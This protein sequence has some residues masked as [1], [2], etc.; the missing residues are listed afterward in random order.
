M[1]S[2]N[3]L[4]VT[5]NQ[6]CL[7]RFGQAAKKTGSAFGTT[8]SRYAAYQCTQYFGN[9]YAD[10]YLPSK[11][12][13]NL[14]YQNLKMKEIGGFSSNYYWSSS[15]ISSTNAWNQPFSNGGQLSG[16]KDGPIYVRA[17]RAF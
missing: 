17:I 4:F 7:L 12:E 5:I 13:L 15:E 2:R 8:D 16:T 1:L 14:M 6:I 10:W 11:N 9:G 3:S